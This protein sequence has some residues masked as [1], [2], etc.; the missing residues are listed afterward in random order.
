MIDY[1]EIMRLHG[2]GLSFRSISSSLGCSRNTVAEVV[3]L[4]EAHGLSWPVSDKLTNKDLEVL[5]YPGRGNSSGR[6]VPDYEYI[7]SELAKPGVTL[8]L[9]WAEYCAQCKLEGEVP[10]QLSQFSEKYRAFAGSKKI[11]LRIKR[12]PGETLEV[13]WAGDTI[14]V[15]DSALGEEIKAY[16]FVACL[17][18]SLYCYAEAFS[19][20]KSHSW[21]RAHMNAFSFFGGV[22]RILVPDNLKTGVI[23]NTRYELILNRSYQEMAEHYG[24]VIIP[25]RPSRPQD[26][27]NV[28]SSVG[29]IETWI[30][31]ALRNQKFFSFE[32]LNFAIKEK[33][34]EL[35]Q[36][37]FQKR[38]GSRLSGFIE[39]EK[40][41]L[42]PLPATPYENALW[43]RVTIQPDYLISVGESKYSVPYEFIGR[44]VDVRSSDKTIEVFYDGNRIASHIRKDGN[45]EPVYQREHMPEKHKKFL[46]YSSEGFID[47][48]EE[49]GK[50]TLAVVKHFLDS[51]CMEQQGFKNCSTLMRL[52]D[53]YS[54]TRLERA[55][56]RALSY[57]PS[58][59][60]KNITTILKNG[61]DKL[62]D[63]GSTKAND[64]RKYGI[65]RGYHSQISKGGIDQ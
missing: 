20:M 65:T 51:G 35:N 1:R 9:L 10:Y 23:K 29:F 38:K 21:I 37:P 60:I 46:C 43:K 52:A 4:W 5:F 64:S 36:K 59:S 2:L 33:L 24:S 15:Y 7:H 57:T 56:K 44:K 58:P 19:D 32:E 48:A 17:P 39:E 11:T 31:A 40:D 16:V 3:K 47:W 22:S 54:T 62:D 8:S 26:K 45:R 13:D 25:T 61:Q 14:S 30:L 27:A 49:V 12:K 50:D 34:H 53:R 28:E 6:K 63:Y 18:C 55:C 41:Y 42:L